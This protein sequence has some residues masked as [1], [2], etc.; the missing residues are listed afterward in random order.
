MP[1]TRPLLL[2]PQPSFPLPSSSTPSPN[3]EPLLT[4]IV[5]YTGHSDIIRRGGALG[6]IKNCAMDRGSMGWLLASEGTLLTVV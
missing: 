2:T 3:D 1:A 4:K 5:V 6:C